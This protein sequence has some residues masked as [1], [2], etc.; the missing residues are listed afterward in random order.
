MGSPAKK[1]TWLITGCS[2]G[3][4]RAIA[5][6]ALE[7][8]DIVVATARDISTLQD[9]EQKGAITCALD[10]T[11][12]DRT[13]GGIVDWVLAQTNGRIDILVN[14]AGYVL[15]G[16]VE[17]CTREEV[18]AIFETNVFGSLNV[19]RAVMPHMRRQRKGAVAFL[20][21]IGSWYGSPSGGLYGATKGSVSLLAEALA[22]EVAHL[23]IKVTA[24]ELGYFRTQ[25][26][27]PQRLTLTTNPIE[28]CKPGVDP[29]LDMVRAY[30][31]KQPGDPAKA[32]KVIVEALTGSGRCEGLE[33]PPRLAIGDSAYPSILG[34]MDR[35]RSNMEEWRAITTGLDFEAE[36]DSSST[37][38]SD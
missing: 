12:D 8:G 29:T 20:G 36:A 10:V 5:L 38:H 27:S 11:A 33:L 14:N 13:I 34:N 6:A 22:A 7:H 9:L 2:T 18:S 31:G 26:F 3:I 16:G 24:L 25:V 23:G 19:L 32:A 15:A 28:E 37:P 35:M 1:D 30:D 21:S 4:G 17:E